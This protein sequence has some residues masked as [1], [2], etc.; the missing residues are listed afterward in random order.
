MTGKSPSTT[1]A[2]SEGALTKG[3]FNA[4]LPIHDLNAALLSYIISGYRPFVTAS[5]YV[6]PNFRVDHDISL[7]VP[8]IL[9]RM[10]RH[11]R[12]PEWLIKNRMLEPVPDLAYQTRTLPS[13][14]LGYRITDDFVNRFMARIFSHPSA[15]FTESMLK[16][17]L[18]DLDAFAE[19]IDNVMSTHRRVAQYYFEDNL[20]LIHI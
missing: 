16:P 5:G 7:L 8:E 4:L 10:E 20:S 11:E 18:Q 17:E 2:G 3:P 9:C 13:S 14:I 15:L 12:D 1:G 19:G 6:G